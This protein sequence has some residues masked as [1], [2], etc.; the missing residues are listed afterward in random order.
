MC[1]DWVLRSVLFMSRLLSGRWKK[2][3]GLLKTEEVPAAAITLD[4]APSEAAV[5]AP[6]APD[7]VAELPATPVTPDAPE[8]N[9]AEPDPDAPE[10]KEDDDVYTDV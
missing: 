5:A 1:A 8:S 4:G 10:T 7:S 3:S 9:S 6:A 2:S